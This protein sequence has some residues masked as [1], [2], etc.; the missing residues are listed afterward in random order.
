MLTRKQRQQAG[1][2]GRRARDSLA[3]MVA[4]TFPLDQYY[5][6]NPQDLFEKPIDDLSVDLESKVILESHLQCAA[7]EMPLRAEDE[8]YFGPLL[9][10]IC[11]TKLVKDKDAW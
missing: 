7:F 8:T 2:A 1:R 4:D 3:I 10:S 5:V 6:Q 9:H 11:E